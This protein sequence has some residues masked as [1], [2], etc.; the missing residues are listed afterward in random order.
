MG[1]PSW[2]S[3][4]LDVLNAKFSPGKAASSGN[5]LA[6]GPPAVKLA[7]RCALSATPYGLRRASLR[8]SSTNSEQPHRK[9]KTQKRGHFYLG[10]KG[11]I[12]I[13]V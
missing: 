12:S 13:L 10:K 5:A 11:D 2:K 1:R 4:L 8:A 3:S 6:S 7:L 9:N